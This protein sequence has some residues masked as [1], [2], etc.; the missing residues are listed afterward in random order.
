MTLTEFRALAERAVA[1]TSDEW[2]NTGAETADGDLMVTCWNGQNVGFVAA[3]HQPEV[4]TWIAAA[5]PTAIIALIERLERAEA[6][7]R[8]IAESPVAGGGIVTIEVSGGGGRGGPGGPE[9]QGYSIEPVTY[10]Q[11]GLFGGGG[12]P[13]YKSPRQIAAAYFDAP[14]GEGEG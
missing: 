2:D 10:V 7:L 5:S 3:T 1:V 8:E 13:D 14:A 9:P 4:A 12:G 6:A 11:D